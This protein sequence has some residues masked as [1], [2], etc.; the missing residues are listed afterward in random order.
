M[1]ASG[2][3]LRASFTDLLCASC[4]HAQMQKKNAQASHPVLFEFV[5][6]AVSGVLSA[7]GW[8]AAAV[9]TD[10]P[11]VHARPNHD[12]DRVHCRSQWPEAQGAQRLPVAAWGWSVRPARG[13]LSCRR[14]QGSF[15]LTA[16]MCQCSRS[17]CVHMQAKVKS[18]T[19]A[20]LLEDY[21]SSTAELNCW[22]YCL[23]WWKASFSRNLACESLP[24]NGLDVS[25][26]ITGRVAIIQMAC[27]W[28]MQTLRVSILWE[29]WIMA[30]CYDAHLQVKIW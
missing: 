18:L 20:P 15:V 22:Q 26:C 4:P 1:L 30:R 24:Q 23:T 14:V 10:S 19:C 11:G 21:P 12:A 2:I 6:N 16:L 5:L 7:V 9:G 13:P 27:P 8:G 29:P 28:L 3:K 25:C 17:Y